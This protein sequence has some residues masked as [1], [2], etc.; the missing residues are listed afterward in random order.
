MEPMLL[1]LENVAFQ[2]VLKDKLAYKPKSISRRYYKGIHDI[3]A[4]PTLTLPPIEKLEY[5]KEV[6]AEL[7]AFTPKGTL[8]GIR[9]T[10]KGIK[11][12]SDPSKD[13]LKAFIENPIQVKLPKLK[14]LK[15]Q[16]NGSNVKRALANIRPRHKIEL[17]EDARR[18]TFEDMDQLLYE[19]F[20]N[21]AMNL[22]LTGFN[23]TRQKWTKLQWESF[24]DNRDETLYHSFINEYVQKVYTS[25][26]IAV[27]CINFPPDLLELIEECWDI[28]H[29][30]SVATA[31]EASGML[32]HNDNEIEKIRDAKPYDHLRA[33]VNYEKARAFNEKHGL[34]TP[35]DMKEWEARNR[36]K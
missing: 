31:L 4:L 26:N 13:V 19:F 17:D 24:E 27:D 16:V 28:Y 21:W 6:Q 9:K 14:R 29:E 1:H 23:G 30:T 15:E 7:P 35:K 5:H 8:H 11:R 10:W 20:D 2:N 33:D 3:P 25:S 22:T 36:G 34:R 18:A 32:L 12:Y